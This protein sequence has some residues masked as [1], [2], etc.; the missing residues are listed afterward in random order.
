MSYELLRQ[1]QKEFPRATWP[2]SNGWLVQ[3]LNEQL[4]EVEV[5]A[6]VLDVVDS[7]LSDGVGVIEEELIAEVHQIDRELFG[8]WGGV[9][10][11]LEFKHGLYFWVR[12]Y[13]EDGRI[14][15]FYLHWTEP[16]I[17]RP[18]EPGE[19]VAKGYVLE[20]MFVARDRKGMSPNPF[21]SVQA[22]PPFPVWLWR[23]RNRW[24]IRNESDSRA[25]DG[26]HLFD[27]AGSQGVKG[28]LPTTRIKCIPKDNSD[29]V[30]QF[31]HFKV[32]STKLASALTRVGTKG[33]N[34]IS[35]DFLRAL[36]AKD[37]GALIDLEFILEE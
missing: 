4:G 12:I 17:I 10:P 3:H 19:E 15:T 25:P 26:K 32:S 30:W 33:V 14:A 34:E 21:D 1:I 20:R 29:H 6:Q 11:W 9:V 36:V 13:D 31:P 16:G 28:Q 5:W 24:S 8:G 22:F 27:S 35:L 18:Y 23:V 7:Y 2:E 37:N